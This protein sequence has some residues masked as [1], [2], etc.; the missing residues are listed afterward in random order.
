MK[1]ETGQS[2]EKEKEQEE[3]VVVMVVVPEE[4][5]ESGQLLEG[6]LHQTFVVH[7][8][9][10]RLRPQQAFEGQIHPLP[11]LP[12]CKFAESCHEKIANKQQ[13]CF[14]KRMEQI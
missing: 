14:L 1:I 6:V 8:V 2:D 11:H 5:E 13:K 7:N 9:Q 3:E 10:R 4:G 12:Y